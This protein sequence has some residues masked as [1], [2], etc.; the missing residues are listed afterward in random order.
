MAFE[1]LDFF[2]REDPA[3]KN[4]WLITFPS[5]K[6]STEY[7]FKFKWVFADT[8]LN[9]KVGTNWSPIYRHL[10]K[11]IG[12]VKAVENLRADYKNLNETVPDTEGWFRVRFTHDNSL[13]SGVYDNTGISYYRITLQALSGNTSRTRTIQW[14]TLLVMQI[15]YLA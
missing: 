9:D 4:Y 10:T 2:G 8:T 12:L 15:K 14:S 5:L 7:D 13:N 1:D 11:S 6:T 3:D